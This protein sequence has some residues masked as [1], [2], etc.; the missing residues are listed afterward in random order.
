MK[1]NVGISAFMGFFIGI[2]TCYFLWKKII[3]KKY[4]KF[5]KKAVNKSEKIIK[6]ANEKGEYIKR[7]KIIHAKKKFFELKSRYER[8]I[9]FKEKRIIE[10]E[11]KI[12]AKENRL[13]KKIEIF[14]KKKNKLESNIHVYNYNIK[15]LKKREEKIKNLY[16]KQIKI[17]ERLSNF[18]SKRAKNE[19][20]KTIIGNAKIQAQ[21]HIQNIIEESQLIAKKEAKKIIIQAIQRLG[22]EPTVENSVSILN[23]ESDDVKGRV[24]GREG[25][26]IK[27]LEKAT[28]VEI[29]IDDTP[30]VILL[31]CFNPI[32]REIARLSLTKLVIDGRIN[33]TK[34]EEIVSKTKKQI[35]EEIIEIGKKNIIDLGIHNIHPKLIK[36]IG[37]MKYRSSYGQNLLQHSR[38]VANLASILSSELGL[39]TKLAKRAGFLHDIGKIPESEPELPHAILGMRWAE[40]YGENT[41]VCNAIGSHHDEIEMKTLISPIIQISDSISG[42]RPGIRK[43]SFESYSKRLKNLEDIALSFYGVNKAFAIKAGRELRVIVESNKINDEETFQ[44]SYNITEKIKNEMT[45]P[46]QI[47]ITVIRETRVIQIA[48]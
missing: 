34:I 40:K 14:Y 29:I 31:S 6:N 25:R 5:L 26:N 35:E 18:S 24:I 19:L 17:L 4:I 21:S 38:E 48:R 39:D 37:K 46:G 9:F 20:F 36:M 23:I 12:K 42:S 30:E 43:N 32:R 22:I 1:I 3:F 10:I 41:I 44:L 15:I 28:G 16:Y 47:K 27:A 7:I 45:Y 33:P 8:N 11:N 13:Y 2:I